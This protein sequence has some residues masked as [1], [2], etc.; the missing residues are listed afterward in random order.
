M[1]FV[2]TDVEVR[3][4]LRNGKVRHLLLLLPA[5]L[6]Q[7][8]DSRMPSNLTLQQK[9]ILLR[10]TSILRSLHSNIH[11]IRVRHQELRIS[12]LERICHLLD[13]VCWTGTRDFASDTKCGVHCHGV[14][15]AVLAEK[16][17]R[18][19]SLEAIAF[20]ES[21]A[22]ICGGFFDFEPVQALFGDGIGVSCEL[23]WRES[24]YG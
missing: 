16:C 4:A 2:L 15:D 13:I 6:D 7:F 3:L 18:V 9:Q 5:H 22:K 17:D 23:V 10:N 14:P 20:H 8:L 21:G 11:T 24:C 19:A 12:S 1:L